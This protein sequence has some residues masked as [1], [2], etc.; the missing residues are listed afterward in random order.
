[1]D[2]VTQ[3]LTGCAAA[4]GTVGFLGVLV[5]LVA[6]TWHWAITRVLQATKETWWITAWVLHCRGE[7]ESAR[8]ALRV[9]IQQKNDDAP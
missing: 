5:G 4:A 1:M 6:L 7:Y 3:I 8:R 9:A 2:T